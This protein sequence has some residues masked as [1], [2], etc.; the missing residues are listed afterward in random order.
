MLGGHGN[1]TFTPDKSMTR[2]EFA[3]MLVKMLGLTAT[4]DKTFGDVDADAW[5]ADAV[6]KAVAA[7]IINGKN[8]DSF[9]PEAP[10]VAI[11]G[12]VKGDVSI[13]GEAAK[14]ELNG[15]VAGNVTV[16]ETATGAE[17][18]GDG[19][20]ADKV[21]NNSAEDVKVNDKTV[22]AKPD[23]TQ[24]PDDTQKPS[25]PDV[26]G[27]NVGGGG[28]GS[29]SGDT[30][31]VVHQHKY[32]S[33]VTKQPSCTAEGVKTYTCTSTTGTCD[34]KTY[35]ESIPKVEHDWGTEETGEENAKVVT[36]K[37]CPATK[38]VAHTNCTD[39]TEAT[40]VTA[41]TCTEGGTTVKYCTVC[42]KPET[43]TT[44]AAGH[45]YGGWET[46][47]AAT[48]GEDGVKSQTCS[49]CGDVK[50]ETIS[51]DTV[52]HQYGNWETVTAATCKDKGSEKRTCSVCNHEETR[53]TEKS[54]EHN[55]GENDRCT[56]CEALKP[57]HQHDFG[58]DG[59]TDCKCGEK[60]PT[61]Q[62]PAPGQS[63]GS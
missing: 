56:V 9:A 47:K 42:G 24:Q 60:A 49:E 34:K 4:S 10:A 15:A 25:T 52:A 48:C 20:T 19:V 30:K 21:T 31:P 39:F 16:E 7:G 36:C 14:M 18:K 27:G 33:E 12:E 23:D 58:T 5:Y 54:T 17:I 6:S 11:E 13:G 37:N 44:P 35:T 41:A 50:T 61:T 28:S 3:S 51:K 53:E 8:P 26:G 62:N 45:K 22:E 1:G 38:P 55:Y 46:T 40:V 29:G 57:D 59:K 32:T 2:A 43:G 63:Q